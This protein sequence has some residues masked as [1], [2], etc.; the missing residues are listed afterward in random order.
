MSLNHSQSLTLEASVDERR[1][2]Q[3]IFGWFEHA[4]YATLVINNWRRESNSK[5]P[6][7]RLITR[8]RSFAPA[9]I[10]VPLFL[11]RTIG[12]GGRLNQLKVS[13]ADKRN[14]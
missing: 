14:M 2:R 6:L 4:S 10:I 7:V 8:L 3:K 13:A 12:L 11:Y 1:F 9:A 5:R